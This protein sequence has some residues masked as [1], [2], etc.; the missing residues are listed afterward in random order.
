M[1]K[2]KIYVTIDENN[3]FWIVVD[4]GRFIRNPSQEDLKY[5]KIISYSKNNICPRCREEKS[6]TDKSILYPRNANHDTDKNGNKIDEWVCKRHSLRNYHRYDP[7]SY[8]NIRKSMT[9]HRIGGLKDHTKI[10]GDNCEELTS[11]LFGA[12]RMSV[13]YDKYS[14][15]PLDHLHIPN[16]VSAII[17][18]KLVDLC[19]KIPQTKGRQYSPEH[20]WWMFSDMQQNCDI[21][22]CYCISEDGDYIERIYV[23]SKEKIPGTH[24]AIL[25][26][27]PNGN[28]YRIE[29]YKD[30]RVIDEKF[31]DN[32]NNVWKE[33]ISR[34]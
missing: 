1:T 22:I 33:I 34:R 15:L 19:G 14:Q 24:I 16:G 28:P 10:L 5:T 6:I 26:H 29:K 13:E 3:S 9:A 21:M 11:I 4:D 27:D 8:S 20:R 31:L 30:S 17:G 12:K 23:F 7:D 2:Y 18:G 32:A 25:K